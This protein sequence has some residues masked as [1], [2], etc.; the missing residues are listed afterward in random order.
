M[1]LNRTCNFRKYWFSN[2]RVLESGADR[3]VEFAIMALDVWVDQWHA[4]Q[5][6]QGKINK[7]LLIQ[8]RFKT[9]EITTSKVSMYSRLM[10]CDPYFALVTCMVLQDKTLWL[11]TMLLERAFVFL[12]SWFKNPHSKHVSVFWTEQW[13]TLFMP[14]SCLALL[15]AA[16]TP[17]AQFALAN[18]KWWSC[19]N[20]L[21]GADAPSKTS[22]SS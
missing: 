11:W 17:G 16:T 10:L 12:W 21:C 18:T 15:R 2:S 6:Q 22:V 3:V 1:T 7:G 8:G 19:L 20:R 13:L 4:D 5:S 9:A 14:V